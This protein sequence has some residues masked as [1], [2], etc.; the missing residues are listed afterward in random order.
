MHLHVAAHARVWWTTPD[1]SIVPT[2]SSLEK[3]MA[4][5]CWANAERACSTSPSK[6]PIL[7]LSSKAAVLFSWRVRRA[8]RPMCP[9]GQAALTWFAVK[10][11]IAR[12][13]KRR[14]PS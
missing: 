5:P 7:N 2:K 3:R 9:Q 13:F 4:P 10:S 6:P 8:R 14:V 11:S 1:A 12:T